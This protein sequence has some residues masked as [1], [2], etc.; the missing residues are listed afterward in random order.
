[1]GQPPSTN[2]GFGFGASQLPERRYHALLAAVL[3]IG[4]DALQELIV[5]LGKVLVPGDGD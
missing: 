5:V 3:Q 1:M 2:D 4:V